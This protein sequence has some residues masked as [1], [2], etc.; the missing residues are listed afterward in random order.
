MT[1]EEFITVQ[2][3]SVATLTR[4]IYDFLRREYPQLKP[5]LKLSFKAIYFKHN[6]VVCSLNP[7]REY[8]SLHYMQGVRLDDPAGILEGSGNKLRHLK[9]SSSEEFTQLRPQAQ[10]FLDQSLSLLTE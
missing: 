6:K 5:D 4:D 9:F 8:V 7:Y 1:I 3:T 2:P 10:E